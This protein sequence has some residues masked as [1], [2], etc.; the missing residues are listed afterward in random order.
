[1]LRGPI[2]GWERDSP[3]C[4][5]GYGKF[6]PNLGFAGAHWAQEYY[7]AFLI[8]LGGFVLHENFGAAG[9]PRLHQNQCSM[10]V[11]CQ[12]GCFFFEAFTL[13]IVSAN[14][15]GDLHQNALTPPART[16]MNGRT[17]LLGHKTS[18]PEYT[19]RLEFVERQELARMQKAYRFGKS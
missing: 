1:M 8:L 6:Q 19:V 5:T 15:H 9:Y 16:W 10:G 18:Y 3:V 2:L 14:T 13:R 17:H 7:M 12:R 4:W 11:D